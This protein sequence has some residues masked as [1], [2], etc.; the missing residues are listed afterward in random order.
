MRCPPRGGSRLDLLPLGQ[1]SQLAIAA[2][3]ARYQAQTEMVGRARAHPASQ[4]GV[5]S[6]VGQG[7]EVLDL[8]VNFAV[9]RET[10]QFAPVI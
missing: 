10:D 1:S 5:V 9:G 3:D 6:Y 4:T 2:R 7:R 8:E